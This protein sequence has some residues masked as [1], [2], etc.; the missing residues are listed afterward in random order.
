MKKCPPGVICIENVSM[1]FIFMCVLILGYLIYSN[2]RSNNI[3]VNNK[4]SDKIVLKDQQ[5]ENGWFG[6]MFPSWPY[7]NLPNDVLLNPYA[8]PLRDERY[9]I[10]S[11]TNIP[12]GSI[13][14]NISTNVGAVD[15]TYRQLGILTPLNGKSKD[16]ILPLMG[17]PLFTNRDKWNYYT[18]SDNNNIVKLPISSRGKNCMSEYGCDSLN[19]GDHVRVEGYNDK[20]KVTIYDNKLMRYLPM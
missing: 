18:M 2:V 5:R 6:G 20:F 4:T 19:S 11:T 17:R 1:F 3:I 15:T 8:P 9:F 10:P 14:I 7:N 12:P 13:P 16:N